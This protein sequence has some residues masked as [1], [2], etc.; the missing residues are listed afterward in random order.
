MATNRR[1]D[2]FHL[3]H[4][5]IRYALNQLQFKAGNLD[6]SDNEKLQLLAHEL[7][8]LWKLLHFHAEGEDAFVMPFLKEANETV[9]HQ[10]EQEHEGFILLMEDIEEDIEGI[11]ALQSNGREERMISFNQNLNEFISKY[12]AHLLHE[13]LLAMPELWEAHTD[14]EL[15]EMQLKFPSITPPDITVYFLKYLFPA[16]NQ[17]ERIQYL[18]IVK[19]KAPETVFSLFTRIARETLNST[20]WEDLNNQLELK[21]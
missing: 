3:P 9:F 15:L 16:L 13:E 14:E 20:D 10:L 6:Y 8:T 17:L 12:A 19:E 4:K 7:H 11:V 2:I 5:G 21:P 1:F 18:K